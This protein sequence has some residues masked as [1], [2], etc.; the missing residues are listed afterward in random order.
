MADDAASARC[1][2]VTVKIDGELVAVP[3]LAEEPMSDENRAYFAEIVAAA[4]RKLDSE[5]RRTDLCPECGFPVGT[6]AHWR[7]RKHA[8]GDAS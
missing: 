2:P 1:R 7:S 6:A 8:G 5:P 4:K 3:V